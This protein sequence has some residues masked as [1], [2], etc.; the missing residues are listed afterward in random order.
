MRPLAAAIIAGNTCWAQRNGPV[1][2]TAITCCHDASVMSANADAAA[3]PALLISTCTGPTSRTAW[4]KARATD[5][6]SRTS[7]TIAPVR[8]VDDR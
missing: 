3:T 4:A 1:R 7:Q 8:P 2:F 5:S 6:V